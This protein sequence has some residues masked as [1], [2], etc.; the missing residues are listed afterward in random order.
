MQI[1]HN[2]GHNAPSVGQ[3]VHYIK[4]IF[5][6]LVESD[7]TEDT[8]DHDKNKSEFDEQKTELIS[9][10]PQIVDAKERPK[11][12]KLTKRFCGKHQL[13]WY[14]SSY[15]KKLRCKGCSAIFETKEGFDQHLR[16]FD[17]QQKAEKVRSFLF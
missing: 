8:L 7:I 4:L 13:R 10:K 17:A 14:Y 15:K 9:D 16:F 1:K 3:F 5:L 6:V 12:I 2:F 11:I